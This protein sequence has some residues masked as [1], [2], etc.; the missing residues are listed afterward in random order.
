MDDDNFNE[1]E[2]SPEQEKNEQELINK[3]SRILYENGIEEVTE[4]VIRNCPFWERMVW[5]MLLEESDTGN[6][7]VHSEIVEAFGRTVADNLRSGFFR[8]KKRLGK[9]FPPK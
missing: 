2:Q 4:W 5:G 1:P 6:S 9:K 8:L 7:M 3:L